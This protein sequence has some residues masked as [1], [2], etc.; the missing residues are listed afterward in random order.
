MHISTSHITLHNP[1]VTYRCLLIACR[2]EGLL[3]A[4]Q[5]MSICRAIMDEVIY[6]LTQTISHH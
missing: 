4:P 5:V 1:V 2:C 3:S 6:K